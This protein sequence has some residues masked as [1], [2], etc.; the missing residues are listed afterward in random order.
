MTGFE[1]LHGTWNVA[2]RRLRERLAGC[3]DWE[4]FPGISECHGFFG[5]AGNFD[6]IEFPT[7]GWSGATLRLLDAE[8]G[9]WSIYWATSRLGLTFPPV[10]GRFEDGVGTFYAD[11]EHEGR[12]V[13]L[14][15]IWSVPA[16]DAPRWEQALSEDGGETWETNWTME[17][18]ARAARARAAAPSA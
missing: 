12:P 5:G 9:L 15:F 1:F 3:E 10:I 2:N 16:P 8:S 14:R 4:E 7:L 11:E 6:E 13:R 17:L 18:S